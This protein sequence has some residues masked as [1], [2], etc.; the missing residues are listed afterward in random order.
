M[1]AGVPLTR[2]YFFSGCCALFALVYGFLG[3]EP[4]PVMQMLLG[5]GPAVAVGRCPSVVCGAHAWAAGMA[6]CS[7]AICD[8]PGRLAGVYRGCCYRGAGKG[9]RLASACS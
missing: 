8:R 2:L 1:S 3:A 5:L 9:D 7:A 4:T 6:A